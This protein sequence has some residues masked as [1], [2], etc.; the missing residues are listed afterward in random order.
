M[1]SMLKAAV[2]AAIPLEIVNSWLIG[3]PAASTGLSLASRSAALALQWYVLHMPGVIASDRSTYLRSHPASCSVVF[4]AAGYIDTAV[5]LVAVF[6]VAR[7]A[8]RRFRKLSSPL[9]HA[10]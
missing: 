7:L 9:K 4:F 6:C 5:L 3:Y 10:H 2:L 8:L 1:R